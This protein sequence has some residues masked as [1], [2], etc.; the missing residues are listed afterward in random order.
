MTLL[1]RF[2]TQARDKHSDPA[3]RLAFLDEVPLDDR[4]TIA[5][6]AHEDEDPRVRRAAVAK[7]M[8]PAALASIARDDRDEAVRAQAS[9]ML[10]DIALEAFE[11]LGEIE[12]LEAVG[13]MTDPRLVSQV[14]KGAAREAVALGALSRIDDVH[15]LGSVARHALA[16]AARLH[17]VGLLQSRGEHAELLAVALNSDFKDSALAAMDSVSDRA[18]LDLVIARGKNKASVKRARTLVREAEERA[19]RDAAQATADLIAAH[20]ALLVPESEAAS[21]AH[22]DPLAA[23][24]EAHDQPEPS[25]EARVH[26]AAEDA[27]RARVRALSDEAAREAAARDADRRQARLLEL[28]DEAAAA[29]ADPDLKTARKRFAAAGREW[30]DQRAG[31]EVDPGLLVRFAESEA[32]LAARE[33]AARDADVRSRRE[34][35]VRLQG[36]IGRVTAAAESADLSLKFADR[37]L[38]DVRSALGTMPGLPTKQDAD[39]VTQRLKALQVVLTPKVHELRESEEWKRFANATIQEQLCEKMEALRSADDLEAVARQV[40]ELQVQWRGAADV[41]R[42]Q[43]DLLWRRF[44]TAHDE[45]WARCE[46]FF[47]AQ[48]AERAENLARKIAL[49]EQAE[50]HAESSNWIPTAD[51]VK[52]LQAEWKTIGPVSRGKEKAIWDR[53]RAACDRFFTRRHADLAERKAVWAENLAKKE[54]LSA[55]AEAAAESIEWDTAAAE[56][57]A[58]QAEW[59]AI[60]P[61]K[62]T[63]S[64][65]VWQ[66]FRAACD[67]FFARYA[68]RHDAA[69][70]ERIAAREALCAELEG[71]AAVDDAPADLAQTVRTLRSRWQQ[72]IAARGV[73]PDRA[74]S[75]DERFGTAFT[76]VVARWPAAFAGSDLDPEANRKRMEALVERMEDLAKALAG[77]TPADA[78]LS[79]TNRLAAMLKEALASNTIGGKA[80]EDAR[81]R[82]AVEDVHQAQTS[83]SKIGLVPEDVRRSLT[84]R[85]QRATRAIAE[86]AAAVA[87]PPVVAGR[88]DLPPARGSRPPRPEGPRGPRP[89]R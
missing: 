3:I 8:M 82:A 6:I 75:L 73:D 63:K 80:S 60:G 84:S 36:L 64:E 77:P 39:D 23:I 61:V 21:P 28:A 48:A 76:A 13:H 49:C 4:D 57:K 9:S 2:R 62:K 44:K 42:A 31:L 51:L 1:D 33:A 54:A 47:A 86:R 12:A 38:R 69:R 83:W 41:P 26:A 34:A 46:T 87:G 72:E 15:A 68:A 17:A 32:A 40:H 22:G 52:K 78:T 79:P 65:V 70:A 66:R 19:V 29:A 59:R 14:A 27:E 30:R 16:D 74:R 37:A 43:A 55:R 88:R 50:A 5:A 85:I 53:F 18:E 25:S 7:L 67:R 81:L 10:R 56:I 89:G 58:L 71:F 20:P 24:V 35:L 11:E 45:V